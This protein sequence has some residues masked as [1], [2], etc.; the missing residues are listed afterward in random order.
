M[1]S[2]T[3]TATNFRLVS[4]ERHSNWSWLPFS[5]F[6]MDIQH[7]LNISSL[8]FDSFPFLNL[9][10]PRHTQVTALLGKTAY[11]TC[12]VKNLGNKTVSIQSIQAKCII[13]RQ[14]V[15][16]TRRTELSCES[17]SHRREPFFCYCLD[18]AEFSVLRRSLCDTTIEIEAKIRGN[19]ENKGHS[20]VHGE[21]S[22]TAK[23]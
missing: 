2:S 13:V 17:A 21:H 5:H 4:N 20:Y 1:I 16:D 7:C 12:R 18:S 11:L 22:T 19:N 3:A 14:K 23:Q 15:V 10:F 9:F 6:K 8:F